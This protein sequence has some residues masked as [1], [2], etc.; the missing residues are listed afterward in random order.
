MSNINYILK[1]TNQPQTDFIK[2][3][4]GGRPLMPESIDCPKCLLC[5]S[6]LTFY[7]S[8]KFPEDHAWAGH[9]LLVFAC[10]NCNWGHPIPEMLES[11]LRGASIPH[12]FL[13]KY[14][15]NFR[16]LVF[17]DENL[18][19][20]ADYDVKISFAELLESRNAEEYFLR[21]SDKPIW[22]LE[23][24]TPLDY[25]DSSLIFLFQVASGSRFPINSGVSPQKTSLDYEE[26]GLKPPFKDYYTLFNANELYFFGLENPDTSIYILTQVD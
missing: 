15:N 12:P 11:N 5:N 17:K 16:V 18:F 3:F 25:N 23:D 21:L 1:A 8:F 10:T 24:E 26:L 19:L 20:K 9:L 7:L 2:T 4:V 13:E 6:Q 14:Q 22:L